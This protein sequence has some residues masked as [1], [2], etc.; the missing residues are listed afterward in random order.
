MGKPQ[1]R[2]IEVS[3]DGVGL[4]EI[5]QEVAHFLRES[6]VGLGLVNLFIQHTSASLVITENADPRVHS[7]LLEYFDRI[8]P[9]SS[10]YR[11]DDEGPD[12]MP[13]HLKTVLTQ[14]SLTIPFNKQGLMLGTWQGLYVCEHRVAAHRRRVVLTIV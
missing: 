8:A 2:V 13:A 14:T 4:F 1:Q 7:D 12:D 11:H 5:S 3:T 9:Q 10:I 6:A